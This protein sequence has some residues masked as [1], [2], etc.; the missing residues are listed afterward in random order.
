MDL[1]PA[2]GSLQVVPAGGDPRPRR[3][4]SRTPR[5]PRS[6]SRKRDDHHAHLKRL[7]ED[8]ASPLPQR[9]EWEALNE[10]VRK[11]PSAS[12]AP[13]ENLKGIIARLIALNVGLRDLPDYSHAELDRLLE[14]R[15]HPETRDFGGP[16]VARR[17]AHEALDQAREVYEAQVRTSS[18]TEPHRGSAPPGGGLPRELDETFKALGRTLSKNI[19]PRRGPYAYDHGAQDLEDDE[20]T[21]D[22]PRFLNTP[23]EVF[24]GAID[25]KWF[26]SLDRLHLLQKKAAARRDRYLPYIVDSGI[27]LWHPL[28]WGSRLAQQDRDRFLAQRKRDPGH[29]LASMIGYSTTF[30]LSHCAAGLVRFESVFAHILLIVRLFEERGGKFAYRYTR[31]LLDRIRTSIREGLYMDVDR[32]ISSEDISIVQELMAAGVPPPPPPAIPS[33]VPASPLKP[34]PTTPPGSGKRDSKGSGKKDSGPGTGKG[35]G[36]Q[37][38]HVCFDHDPLNS[39]VCTLGPGCPRDHLDTRQ[40]ALLARY[41]RALEVFNKKL[42]AKKLASQK[43]A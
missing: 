40:P 11:C 1:R 23:V 3:S 38:R 35:I 36:T 31:A 27:E 41:N 8:L 14:S 9:S 19:P 22:L 2:P 32:A 29:S 5:R 13:E 43:G 24:P 15:D 28:W 12:K 21:F 16:G 33:E 34:G 39:K 20:E 10:W 26:A 37:K 17:C 25:S 42:E 7:E 6:G 30:W 18:R 4:R